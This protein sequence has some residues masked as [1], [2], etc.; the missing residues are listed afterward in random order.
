MKKKPNY[1]FWTRT[2]NTGVKFLYVAITLTG[3]IARAKFIIK[4]GGSVK[5]NHGYRTDISKICY[6]QFHIRNTLPAYAK[7]IA[8]K[9]TIDALSLLLFAKNRMHRHIRISKNVIK[10]LNHI[11]ITRLFPF[12][13]HINSIR[14]QFDKRAYS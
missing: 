9:P 4:K 5:R 11:L 12:I 14:N 10:Y 6:C 3:I 8:P 2:R 7:N 1:R 13:V